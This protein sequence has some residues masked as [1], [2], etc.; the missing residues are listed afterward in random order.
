[1]GTWVDDYFAAWNET[2]ADRV[3]EWMTDDVEFEDVTAGHFSR[4]KEAA[5]RFVEAC[6]RKVPDARYEVVTSRSS[7][8]AYWVEW[9]M[10][11]RGK[12]VRG[13][14][15]GTRRDGKIASNHDYWNGALF[16][17]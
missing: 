6:Y 16:Q 11:A 9:V 3:V 17:V 8:D 10:H 15:V 12:D 4:G 13:A 2:N 1:M 14:S 5:K 7:G